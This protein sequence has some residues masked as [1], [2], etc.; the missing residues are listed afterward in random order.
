MD[1]GKEMFFSDYAKYFFL[2]LQFLEIE[3][4]K[5]IHFQ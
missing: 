1:K 4:A 2:V 3:M 5:N